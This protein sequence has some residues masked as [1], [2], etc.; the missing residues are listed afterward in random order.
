MA[1]FSIIASEIDWGAI[2]NKVP[3]IVVALLFA[4]FALEFQKRQNAAQDKRDEL[5]EKRN[6]ALVEAIGKVTTA[7]GTMAEQHLK[8]NTEMSDA[9]EEMRAASKDLTRLVQ[10]RARSPKG[11]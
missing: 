2:V 10:S 3:E 4:W 8:H 5:Y 9:V 6:N 7:V 11:S 1:L